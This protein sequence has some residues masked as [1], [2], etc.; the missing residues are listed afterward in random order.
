MTASETLMK[1]LIRAGFINQVSMPGLHPDLME[2]FQGVAGSYVYLNIDGSDGGKWLYRI[3]VQDG[4]VRIDEQDLD[5][6]ESQEYEDSHFILALADWVIYDALLGEM[7]LEEAMDHA[8]WGGS[9]ASHPTWTFLKMSS[10]LEQ[11]EKLLD[12]QA[13]VRLMRR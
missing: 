5:K 11:F 4:V 10:L 7:T 8:S 9:F 3:L 1:R 6:L 2:F 12:R 13:I